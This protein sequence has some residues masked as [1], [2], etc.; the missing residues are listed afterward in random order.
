MAP[1]VSHPF[2]IKRYN[3]A[4]SDTL[5]SVEEAIKYKKEGLYDWV[6][7]DEWDRTDEDGG[8]KT[9]YNQEVFERLKSV[10]YKIALVTPELHGTSPR[11]LGGEAHPDAATKEKLFARIKEILSLSPDALCADYPEEALNLI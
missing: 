9:L 11:L 6:W 10:G 7:L 5:I 2:D 8:N 1:S 4:V 3:Q